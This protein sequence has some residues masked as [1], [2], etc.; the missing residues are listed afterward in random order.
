GG[1]VVEGGAERVAELGVGEL[2]ARRLDGAAVR[3]AADAAHPV[4]EEVGGAALGGGGALDGALG[5]LPART[6]LAAVGLDAGQLG[7]APRPPP[8]PP[9]RPSLGVRTRAS[10]AARATRLASSAAT[11]IPAIATQLA[12]AGASTRAR[13][14]TSARSSKKVTDSATLA[15]GDSTAAAVT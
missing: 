10:P 7:A 14:T 1:G 11:P 13:R 2:P 8:A 9:R 12:P 15:Q 6:R 3:D 5:R 4:L